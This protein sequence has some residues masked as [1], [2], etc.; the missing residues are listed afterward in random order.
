MTLDQKSHDSASKMEIHRILQLSN[1]ISKS[2]AAIHDIL[3]ARGLPLPSF[4]ADAPES[5][6]DE[7]SAAQDA[8]LDASSEL[9]DLLLGPFNTLESYGSVSFT[10]QASIGKFKQL[11]YSAQ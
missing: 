3:T 8:V 5:L 6:P 4:D 11:L 2:T 10:S 9:H 7:V 1:T